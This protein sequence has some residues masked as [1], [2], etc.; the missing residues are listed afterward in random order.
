MDAAAPSPVAVAAGLEGVPGWVRRWGRRAGHPV[1]A[2][3]GPGDQAAAVSG[4]AALLVTRG[5]PEQPAPPVVV[6]AVRDLPADGPVLAAAA[7]AAGHLG[8]TV[9][10]VHAVPLSFGERSVGLGDAVQRG[11]RLLDEAAAVLGR[12]GVA[13][14]VRL[15]RRWP[16]EV[17]GEDIGGGL[18]VLGTAHRDPRQP[19]GPVARSAL[20]HAPCPVLIVPQPPVT[21]TA[22]SAS[23]TW[24]GSGR[25]TAW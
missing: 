18:L 21:A 25:S 22:G 24:E 13:A 20:C 16:H 17:V 7:D 6:A 11:L 14:E 10:A 15:V 5:H 23:P 4:G 8:G 19:F 3:P 12:T 2:A 9:L 1:S